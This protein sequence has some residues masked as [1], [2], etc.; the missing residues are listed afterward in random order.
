MLFLS[1]SQYLEFEQA[2]G[3]GA[4]DTLSRK[5]R[6]FALYPITF[7]CRGKREHGRG[8]AREH[9]LI[10]DVGTRVVVSG[11]RERDS[12]WLDETRRGRDGKR[13]ICV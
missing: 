9:C 12:N 7:V 5:G 3:V 4:R 2:S 6:L 10:H 8:E 1:R 11:R 13:R